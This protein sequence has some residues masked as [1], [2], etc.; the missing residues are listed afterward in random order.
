MVFTYIIFCPSTVV[1]LVARGEAWQICLHRFFYD[2]KNTKFLQ[3]SVLDW[4]I[5]WK[6][7]RYQ[8]W[9]SVNGKVHSPALLKFIGFIY[10]ERKS[11][12]SQFSVVCSLSCLHPLQCLLLILFPPLLI[13]EMSCKNTANYRSTFQFPWHRPKFPLVFIKSLQLQDG[14]LRKTRLKRTSTMCWLKQGFSCFSF[15]HNCGSKPVC[16]VWD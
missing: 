2:I 11:R 5:F 3:L 13:T 12:D 10:L 7:N 15:P 6:S 4:V 9:F 8:I 14:Q 1:R 16:R